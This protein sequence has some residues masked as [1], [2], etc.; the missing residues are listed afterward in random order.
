MGGDIDDM[1]AE[2]RLVNI[3]MWRLTEK[4]KTTA[5]ETKS[6]LSSLWPSNPSLHDYFPA[7]NMADQLVQ[8]YLRTMESTH[9]IVHIPSF[10]R[11]YEAYWRDPQRTSESSALKILLIMAIGTCFYQEADSA[12]LRTAAKQWV[13]RAQV[14]VSGP[15]DKNRLNLSGLQIQCLLLLARHTN[16]VGPDLTWIA[17]GT[18]LHSSCQLG[19]HRDPQ[20]FPQMSIL[21]SEL[22]RRLW[23]TVLDL[24]IQTALETGMVPILALD[25]CNTRPPANI[26]DDAISSTTATAPTPLP[27]GVYTDTSLQIHLLASLPTRYNITRHLNILSSDPVPPYDELIRL[28]AELSATCNMTAVALKTYPPSLAHPTP[29]HARHL[30]LSTRRFL[31]AA[32]R[33]FALNSNAT[34]DNSSE[35]WRHVFSR[36]VCLETAM[37]LTKP[38]PEGKTQTVPS[39]VRTCD[40]T[41]LLHTGGGFYRTITLSA[42]AI[43]CHF[44]IQQ[45]RLAPSPSSSS[46]GPRILLHARLLQL[47]DLSFR[48]FVLGT[49]SVKWYLLLSIALGHADALERAEDGRRGMLEGAKR[50]KKACAEVLGMQDVGRMGGEQ[51]LGEVMDLTAK[52]EG[53]LGWDTACEDLGEDDSMMQGHDAWA[54][55]DF[56]GGALN[57]WFVSGWEENVEW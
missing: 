9:R 37:V 47:T 2:L 11:E 7:R 52:S 30:D 14:W 34:A 55:F 50:G 51:V 57:E 39:T 17:T 22:R 16:D 4:Y 48:R 28:G 23:A 15:L 33:P 29:F 20:Y 1:A 43:M 32:H 53:Q 27:A 25:E 41:R 54:T 26:N 56:D 42:F 40:Y 10:N 21:H 13:H 18:L 49:T 3:E 31:F 45:Y 46:S 8:N 38:E 44:L 24:A 19:L 6:S 5:R 12:S 36:E 35:E